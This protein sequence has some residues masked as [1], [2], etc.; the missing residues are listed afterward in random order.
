MPFIFHQLPIEADKRTIYIALTTQKGLSNW[1][2]RDCVARAEVGFINEF[3]FG[4]HFHNK[5]QVIALVQNK[6]VEW[7]VIAGAEEWIGTLIRFEI[8]EKDGLNFI[9]FKHTGY[10][11]ANDF[12]ASCNY[13]WGRYMM[14]LKLY[15]E[16]GIGAPYEDEKD[17]REVKAVH[18]KKK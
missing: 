12:Y 10:H 18:S 3:I 9:S 4:N 8:I 6:L 14:S 11:E 5:M 15:C 16:T 17:S 2:T 7:K 13:N 1:W